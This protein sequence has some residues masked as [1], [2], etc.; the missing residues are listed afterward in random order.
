MGEPRGGAGGAA[1]LSHDVNAAWQRLAS[2]PTPPTP[3]GSVGALANRMLVYTRPNHVPAVAP[4]VDRRRG[5]LILAG[6]QTGKRMRLL[7]QADFDA[8]VLVDPAA[9]EHY[10]ATPEQPFW[11][12]QDQLSRLSLQELLD[13]QLLAGAT[14]ALTPTGYVRAGDTDSLKA[15]AGKVKKL[16][17]SDTILVAP[18]DIA[19]LGKK[20]INQTIAILADAG[21]PVALILGKQFDPLTQSPAIIPNLRTLALRVPLLAMRTDFNAFDL[22]AHGAFAGAI[23]T[24]GS[25]RHT[26]EPPTKPSAFNPADASPS[27]LFPHLICWWKGSKIAK[28]YGARPRQAARCSCSVCDGERLSRFLRRSDQSEALRHGVAVW[29]GMAADMLDAPTM[30]QRAEYWRNVC[31]GSVAEHE[32]I[33]RQLQMAEPPYHRS[34]P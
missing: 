1:D 9:Y 5:G 22:V 23:G 8:P 20:F 14:A 34:S 24:G 11:S 6:A 19:L 25:I 28:L 10:A 3:A 18:L 7:D 30:R 31:V 4:V 29:S 13:Q 2:Q 21:C 16:Q 12:P 33:P 15:A 26:V 32:N 17:R 27:V